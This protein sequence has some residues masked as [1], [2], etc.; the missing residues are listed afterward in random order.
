MTTWKSKLFGDNRFN[1]YGWIGA[2]LAVIVVSI[3]MIIMAIRAGALHSPI[4]L[5]LVAIYFVALGHF[6]VALQNYHAR[7]A[8]NIEAED[9]KKSGKKDDAA[10]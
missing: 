1:F 6:C 10:A 4:C 5:L 8:K 3:C 2:G 9:A 7:V